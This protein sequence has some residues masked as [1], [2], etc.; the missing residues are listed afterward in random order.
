MDKKRELNFFKTDYTKFSVSNLLPKLRFGKNVQA[1][2][3]TR[4]YTFEWLTYAVTYGITIISDTNID[5]K[6]AHEINLAKW[7]V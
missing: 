4:N 5:R 3:Y 6:I 2:N 7:M 1:W